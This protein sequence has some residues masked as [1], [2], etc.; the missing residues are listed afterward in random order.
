MP[1][2]CTGRG[3]LL[4]LV[5]AIVVGCVAD[6][7]LPAG[8]RNGGL[9]RPFPAVLTTDC[10]VEMDDQWAMTHL[11]LSR[12][13]DLRAVITTHASSIGFSS[14]A[15]AREAE[16]VIDRVMPDR[17]IPRPAVVA[18]SASP[19]HDSATP[20]EG[21]GADL[22][23][24]LSREFS[25]SRRL[26]IFV[27][28]AATDVASALLKDPSVED[29]VTIVA[30]GFDDW[31]AGGDVFN[32]KNDALAWQAILRSDVPVVVGSSAVTQRGLR[33]TR[34]E[35]RAM[36]KGRGPLGDYLYSL[37]DKWLTGQAAL[38]AKMVAPDTWVIW[39]EV[40]AAYALGMAQ[41]TEVPRP[42][43]QP[44]L[45]FS[46]PETRDR[47]TWITQIDTKRVWHDFTGK[48]E[49]RDDLHRR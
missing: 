25:R 38:V 40:V 4:V 37:F 31:P 44:N 35:A 18:G 32:V 10:G 27:T 36:M 15:S 42:E 30:M 8:E 14:A 41:G 7:P 34:P 2:T 1:H 21:A 48:I 23:L 43:L 49:R 3:L 47:I 45:M 16:A 11:L 24:R 12:E 39:D 22:L 5:A 17:A 46:H 13:V 9:Q 19:L 33:L 26:V 29:R 20:R 28:G 6:S